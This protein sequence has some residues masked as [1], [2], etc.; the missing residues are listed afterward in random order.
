MH[1]TKEFNQAP[2]EK[3]GVGY[4]SHQRAR[5]TGAQNIGFLV[6]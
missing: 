3:S 2:D 4:Q 6:K 1:M 5:I